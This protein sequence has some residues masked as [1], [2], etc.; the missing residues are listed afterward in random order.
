MQITEEDIF[1][2]VLFPDRLSQEANEYIKQ[3]ENRF[4]HQ[5]EFYKMF[6][7]SMNDKEISALAKKAVSKIKALQNIITLY[8]VVNKNNPGGNSLTL[9]AAS[10]EIA[11]KQS[12]SISYSDE[13]SKYLVRL[14]RDKDKSILYF[15]SN[16]EN[17]NQNL[18]ITFL[19][20]NF[21]LH[22]ENTSRQIE[23]EITDEIEK[24]VIDEE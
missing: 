24:I 7:N 12:E 4:E 14:I 9:A 16:T 17:K 2:Y 19:P 18:K 20:T 23:L 1:K 10:Q 13:N 11:K 15:F 5:I 6:M 8:P 21:V 3:N 22:I